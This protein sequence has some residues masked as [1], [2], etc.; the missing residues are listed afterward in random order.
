MRKV[1]VLQ[2]V[3]YERQGYIADYMQEHN[4]DFDVVRLWEPY[5]VPDVSEY[6]ALIIMG[7]PMGVTYQSGY[8]HCSDAGDLSRE[9]TH[10]SCA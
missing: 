2:H 5:V 7:G 9:S 6:S 1:L 4:L 10:R 3:P 8:R